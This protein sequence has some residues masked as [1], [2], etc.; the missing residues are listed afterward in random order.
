MPYSDT[1]H[2]SRWSAHSLSHGYSSL[3][4]L[5]LMH[6]SFGFSSPPSDLVHLRRFWKPHCLNRV[7]MAVDIGL[8]WFGGCGRMGVL[9]GWNLLK[10]VHMCCFS[11]VTLH[12]LANKLR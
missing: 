6:F 11:F 3:S 9:K 12:M 5:D 2:G 1:S 7:R 8:V 10:L 4:L